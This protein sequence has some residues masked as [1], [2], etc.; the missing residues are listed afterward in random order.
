[1]RSRYGDMGKKNFGQDRRKTD[2]EFP[3]RARSHFLFLLPF[4]S[5]F[6]FSCPRLVCRRCSLFFLRSI[7]AGIVLIYFIII[8]QLF[9]SL[10]YFLLLF[11]SLFRSPSTVNAT[12]LFIIVIISIIVIVINIIVYLFIVYYYSY[13]YYYYHYHHIVCG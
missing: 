9:S 1:M 2:L 10:C 13:C 6:F 3:F 8:S 11:S 7:G 12:I 4:L 5:L